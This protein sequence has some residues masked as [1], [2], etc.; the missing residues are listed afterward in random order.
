MKPW[1]LLDQSEIPGQQGQ[2][3]LHRHDRDMVI[4]IN[5]QELMSTRWHASE[6]ALGEV[7]CAPIA[8]RTGA[9]VMIGGLGLGFTLAAALKALKADAKVVVAEL[10]PAVV[11]WNRG[12]LGDAAGRP[13]DDARVEIYDGD[14]VDCIALHKARWD[15]ILLDVDN[16]PEA[17]TKKSNNALYGPEGLA[18]AHAALKPGGMFA[19]WSVSEEKTFSRRLEKTGFRVETKSIYAS[20]TRGR[21][22][23]IWFATKK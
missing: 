19:V 7:G 5:G 3:T 13:M 22:H 18:T 10:V 11:R 15:A 9:Q 20:G 4:R 8:N 23:V 21:R 6:D 16:G 1:E 2:L 17:L 14:V 12:P